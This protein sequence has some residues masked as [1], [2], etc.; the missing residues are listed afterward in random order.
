MAIMAIL[1]N[2][3]QSIAVRQNRSYSVQCALG[4]ESCKLRVLSETPNT[5]QKAGYLGCCGGYIGERS[6]QVLVFVF[7]NFAICRIHGIT[8]C[9]KYFLDKFEKIMWKNGILKM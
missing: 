1:L 9:G 5:L 4:A 6:I 2:G 3:V 7:C 8:V